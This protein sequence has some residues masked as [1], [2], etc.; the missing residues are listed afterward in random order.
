M[1][2]YNSGLGK[3]LLNQEAW[4]ECTLLIRVTREWEAY[5]D[6]PVFLVELGFIIKVLLFRHFPIYSRINILLLWS[7]YLPNTPP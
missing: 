1:S 3:S 6:K 5:E 4:N 2:R 7:L